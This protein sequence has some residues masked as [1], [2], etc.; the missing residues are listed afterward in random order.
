MK[1]EIKNIIYDIYCRKS[2]E[3]EERQVLSLEGQEKEIKEF[4]SKLGIK[5]RKIWFESFS[6]KA[7][8]RP[9]FNEMMNDV[10]EGKIQGIVA[11]HPDRLSRNSVDGGLIIYYLDTGYLKDLLFPTYTYE[12][13]PQ[14]K[15]MLNI[16]FGQSKYYVDQLSIN[17]KRGNRVKLENGWKPSM[18]P[19]GYLNKL[20]DKTI[21]PDPERFNILQSVLIDIINGKSSIKDAFNDLNN[22]YGYKTLQRKKSGGRTL[23]KSSFYNIL[24]NSFYCGIIRHNNQEYPGKHLPMITIQEFDKLQIILGFK[25]KPRQQNRSFPLTGF[26][27]CSECG[28]MITAETHNKKNSKTNQITTYTYYRC[29]KKN[30]HITCNQPYVSEKELEQQID[31]YLSKISIS[32]EFKNWA[33]KYLDYLNDNEIRLEKAAFENVHKEIEKSRKEL[34]TATTMRVKGQI[35]DII[36]EDEKKRINSELNRLKEISNEVER[37]ADNW[38]DLV[39]NTVNFAYA[40]R[41]QFE[42]GDNKAKR[43]VFSKLGSNFILKDKKLA[44][45]LNKTLFAF[46]PEYRENIEPLEIEEKVIVTLEKNNL[47]PADLAWL[48]NLDSNQD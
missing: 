45:E 41:L 18:A 8:G 25:G 10:R 16:Q 37:N 12:N 36:Y 31:T 35:D 7:P 33:L 24:N 11:W 19:T 5:I 29:T 40:A 46:T 14:G 15:W 30:P 26:I 23:A 32:E 22:K 43:Y 47:V 21:I 39:T 6:A 38:V 34:Q 17:V 4:A 27:K 1:N 13:T 2:Q 42:N 3:S 20:D 28:S 48:P 44:M 9:I